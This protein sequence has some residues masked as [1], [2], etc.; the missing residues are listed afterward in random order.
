MHCTAAATWCS[1]C[2]GVVLRSARVLLSVVD[3]R[4]VALNDRMINE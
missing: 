3:Y 4:R 1:R 2:V